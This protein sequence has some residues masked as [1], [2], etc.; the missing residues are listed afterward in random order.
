MPGET[1]ERA[2]AP[3]APELTHEEIRMFRAMAETGSKPRDVAA[4]F[5]LPVE[6]VVALAPMI[7]VPPYWVVRSV[8][9]R[10]W[11]HRALRGA[12]AAG[13]RDVTVLA[14]LCGLTEG[15][16]IERA[17]SEF[18]IRLRPSG[19]HERLP[20][21]RRTG[22]IPAF[23]PRS[24]RGEWRENAA[25]VGRAQASALIRNLMADMQPEDYEI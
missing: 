20:I 18:G 2:P 16:V 14:G 9:G 6:T 3:A 24:L 25:V 8:H 21:D 5:R 7:G 1:Q 19:G 4:H 22:S 15:S 10:R 23:V 11:A 12:L 13:E 17:R